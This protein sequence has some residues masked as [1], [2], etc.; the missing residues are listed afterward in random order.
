MSVLHGEH[1]SQNSP[2]ELCLFMTWCINKFLKFIYSL[3]VCACMCYVCTHRMCWR[4]WM[5][6]VRR[7][8]QSW[9]YEKLWNCSMSVLGIGL[10]FPARTASALDY[11]AISLVTEKIKNKKNTVCVCFV[12]ASLSTLRSEDNFVEL[13][14]FFHLY[15]GSRMERKQSSLCGRLFTCWTILSTP[16]FY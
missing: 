9:S 2:H 3:I 1:T 16:N 10:V 13:C 14:L 7:G 15:R 6:G 12:S 4:P 8:D 5:W 11:E